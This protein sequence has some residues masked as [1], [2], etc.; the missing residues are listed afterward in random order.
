MKAIIYRSEV[1]KNIFNEFRRRSKIIKLDLS[2]ME[3]EWK[4]SKIDANNNN[5]NL[6]I[7]DLRRVFLDLR[8]V[9]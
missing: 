6:R 1:F 4:A 7:D 9:F 2:K 3:N 8:R 5:F